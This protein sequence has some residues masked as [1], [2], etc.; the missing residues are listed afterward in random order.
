LVELSD[1][2]RKRLINQV[3]EEAEKSAG[4]DDIAF[5]REFR[6]K[7]FAVESQRTSGL[8]AGPRR[9]AVTAPEG[10]FQIYK[11]PR[12]A[13]NARELAKRTMG[14]MR[15]IGGIPVRGTAFQDCVAVG[16]D[17]EWYC[18]GTL[19]GP[20]VVLTAG[21]CAC[22]APPTKIFI[23]NSVRDKG[24]VIDVANAVQHEDYSRGNN[25]DLT[26]LILKKDVTGVKPRLTGS[27]AQINQATDAR[28][29]GFGNTDLIG[30]SGYGIK[31]Q[32]D[33]PIVSHDCQ[34][35]VS[36]R[37]DSKAYGCDRGLELIAGK[38]ML[39]KDTCTGD[40]GGPL[41]ISDGQG[42]WL[43]AGATSRATRAAINNC[44]DGGVY[45]R[46]D[47]YLPWIKS[48]QGVKIRV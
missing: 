18:S 37:D 45:V 20:N 17:N 33:V 3:I 13:R 16:D 28:V 12:Y 34:G 11:D 23:G 5:V 36:G 44:G 30:R 43:L 46:V 22:G 8:R 32:T 42:E 14:G 26:V 29:V 47:K 15:I 2:E 35:S 38:P 31:R 7:F 27:S 39:A 10:G 41:Y 48:L 40:S 25:N 21:H 19:I 24:K 4:Q 1:A 9:R 6:S